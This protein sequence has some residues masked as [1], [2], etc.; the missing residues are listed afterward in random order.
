MVD[1]FAVSVCAS[2]VDTATM[3]HLRWDKS[4]LIY[5]VRISM[6]LCPSKKNVKYLIDNFYIDDMLKW[7]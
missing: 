6:T 4:K 5:A 7:Y 2:C 1:H 3:G